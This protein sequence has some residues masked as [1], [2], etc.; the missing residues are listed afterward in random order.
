MMVSRKPVISIDIVNHSIA[1]IG[2]LGFQLALLN[3]SNPLIIWFTNVILTILF[4][5]FYVAFICLFIRVPSSYILSL[6]VLIH[7][8]YQREYLLIIPR[9]IPQWDIFIQFVDIVFIKIILN[10]VSFRIF[11]ESNLFMEYFTL[12]L[13]KVLSDL[14]VLKNIL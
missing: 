11:P 14:T 5:I 6:P 2:S 13:Y 7:L 8:C 4:R 12:N 10:E 1:R 9:Q 3:T